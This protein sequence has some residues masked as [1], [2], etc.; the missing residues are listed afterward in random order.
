MSKININE[1]LTE[2]NELADDLTAPVS[3]TPATP[4]QD[5]FDGAEIDGS[6][7]VEPP[8]ATGESNATEMLAAKTKIS[9]A[10]DV[11]KDAF[12]DFQDQIVDSIELSGD[13]D[14]LQAVDALSNSVTSLQQAITPT[15]AAPVMDYQGFD[16]NLPVDAL[17]DNIPED[18]FEFESDDTEGEDEDQDG[19]GEDEL[20]KNFDDEA[21]VD[22]DSELDKEIED[23]L[24]DELEDE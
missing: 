18:D 12:N 22:I 8:V 13:N 14:I 15:Q 17:D 1:I 16:A 24:E 4:V 20:E 23:E 5:Q 3:S 6:D 2:I 10:F 9:R 21:Q 11:L 19:L 7:V